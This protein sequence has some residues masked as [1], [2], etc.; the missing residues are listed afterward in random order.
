M[1]VRVLGT[2]SRKRLMV[3]LYL[4]DIPEMVD[5][6]SSCRDARRLWRSTFHTMPGY[7]YMLLAQLMSTSIEIETWLRTF[8]SFSP[9]N[10]FHHNNLHAVHFDNMILT[11]TVFVFSTTQ[12]SSSNHKNKPIFVHLSRFQMTAAARVWTVCHGAGR[13]RI[14]SY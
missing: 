12:P 13:Y 3:L 6:L 5:W 8:V 2:M 4:I 10:N 1:H 7:T 14:K 9:S 11:T